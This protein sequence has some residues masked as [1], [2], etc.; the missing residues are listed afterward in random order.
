[1]LFSLLNGMGQCQLRSHETWNLRITQLK[2]KVIFHP[3]QF[4][5]SNCQFSR[6]Y[7]SKLAF[8][9]KHTQKTR[10]DDVFEREVTFFW[11]RR[12]QWPAAQ[13]CANSLVSCWNI[14]MEALRDR[15]VKIIGSWGCCM[16]VYLL[17][18][19]KPA[20][21]KGCQLNPKGCWIDTL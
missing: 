2:R 18:I 12:V 3:P 21:S 7:L 1:M 10:N 19:Y 8:R 4:W 5:G 16:C 6:V 13:M 9:K 15:C 14:R 20:P 11:I 17:N